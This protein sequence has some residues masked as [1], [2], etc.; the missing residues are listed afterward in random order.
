MVRI[1]DGV[2]LA[3]I[4]ILCRGKFSTWHNIDNTLRYDFAA[5]D[6]II[7]IVGEG[8]DLIFP[9]VCQG[10]QKA[11]LVAVE[12]GVAHR[13]FGFV[14]IA[15]KA[16]AKGCCRTGKDTGAAVARLN[17]FGD[18]GRY[19]EILL[20]AVCQ[21]RNRRMG[22]LVNRVVNGLLNRDNGILTAQIIRQFLAKA[23]GGS[24]VKDAGHVD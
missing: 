18:K 22:E 6:F 3:L 7:H 8:I 19:G 9:K 16:A 24:G 20:G 11:G 13:G 21:I 14:G 2:A 1:F 23:L 5:V 15:G 17:V 4:D 10:C 12:G